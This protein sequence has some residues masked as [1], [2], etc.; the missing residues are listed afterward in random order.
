M[1]GVKV[2]MDILCLV[3]DVGLMRSCVLLKKKRLKLLSNLLLAFL[4]LKMQKRGLEA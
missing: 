3:R 1:I 2:R 4:N